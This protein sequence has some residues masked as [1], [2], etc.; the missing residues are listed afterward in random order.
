MGNLCTWT[1]S[2]RSHHWPHLC[3]VLV[4]LSLQSQGLA[5]VCRNDGVTW[6]RSHNF[7]WILVPREGCWIHSLECLVPPSSRPLVVPSKEGLV[8]LG[9]PSRHHCLISHLLQVLLFPLVL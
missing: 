3:Q 2:G 8:K 7:E 6:L 9:G 1:G 4:Q 5:R